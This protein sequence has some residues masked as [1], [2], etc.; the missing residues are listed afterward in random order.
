MA[1]IWD[2]LAAVHTWQSSH[3]VYW[4]FGIGTFIWVLYLLFTGPYRHL[5]GG[6][7]PPTT[8]QHVYM[9][10]GML[11]Y[12][13]AFASP[14]D[15]LSDEYLFSAHMV[16]H[17]LEVS[18]MVPLLLM[19]LPNW[20]WSWAFQWTPFK[21]VFGFMV[22]PFVALITFLLIFDNFHWPVLYDLT[23]VNDPFHVTEHL[24]FFFSAAF[25]W[26]PVLST[27]PEFPA[28]KPGWRLL[29]LFFAFDVMMPPAIFLFMWNTPLY[30]PY[31]EAPVRLF[32]LSPMSD[33]RLGSVIMVVFGALSDFVAA[34][35]AFS[36]LDM[37]SW[38]E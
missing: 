15:H 14:L 17:M 37:T 35:A 31:V 13:I 27:H 29:Y 12:Y 11:S 34:F 22:N 25:L 7:K 28:V 6:D 30:H 5:L 10:L 20:L 16:Q 36:H 32:G 19:A 21:K 4:A 18:V 8:A 33:Q 23:L 1:Y 3:W 26:W 2:Q 38:N 24:L 9:T